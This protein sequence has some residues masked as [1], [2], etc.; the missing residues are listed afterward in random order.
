MKKY[1]PAGIFTGL[2]IFCTPDIGSGKRIRGK[3]NEIS[4]KD[5]PSGF[6]ALILISVKTNPKK[7]DTRCII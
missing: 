5:K 4:Y 1:T 3:A 7:E 2:A 6:I